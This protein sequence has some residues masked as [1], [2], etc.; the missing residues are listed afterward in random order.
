[1]K[2]VAGIICFLLISH[3]CSASSL[4]SIVYEKHN[5][6]TSIT[7]SIKGFL[8]HKI[9]MLKAPNRLVIDLNKTD[10][11]APINQTQATRAGF[12]RVRVG[13][14]TASTLRIVYE[15]PREMSF[16]MS[17]WHAA[18][19]QNQGMRVDLFAKRLGTS[20]PK[21]LPKIVKSV[22]NQS[23][24]QPI[25]TSVTHGSRNV[26]VVLDAGHGGKDPGAHGERGSLEKNVT[27][28]IARQLK[29]LID[30]Q[31]GMQAVLTRSGDYYVGLRER[32]MIARRYKADIF[33]SIHADAFPN[34][35]SNGA[36]VFALSP[37]GATSEAARWLAAK[38][39]HSELGGVNLRGL[40]DA[41]GLVRT[42][43]V[44]LSQTATINASLKM[45]N[46]VLG[47]LNNLTRLH[48]RKVEQAGFVVLKSPDI[49]SILVETG[50]ITNPR[51]ESNLTNFNYQSK[52]TQSI[53][54][55][56][57][58]YFMEYPPHGTR[59]EAMASR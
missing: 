29:Q 39:N 53:F 38:E 57:R 11:S 2:R 23:T 13:H 49:P 54:Q 5:D 58:T 40:D 47:H 18:G 41:N 12:V 28:G 17:P 51:E 59:L 27:L 42:V 36:S 3:L 30:R 22:I 7:L 33:V 45:G 44:D 56:L 50:F 9:F 34:R 48:S 46:H 31:P 6:R 14:P 37:R 55:G 25:L 8:S 32:L 16:V 26:I 24:S 10:L 21:N 1:M 19:Y 35:E 15:L 43:L 4:Q 52:L 20:A